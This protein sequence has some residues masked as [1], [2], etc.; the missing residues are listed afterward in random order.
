MPREHWG[1][2][3]SRNTV[4]QDEKGAMPLRVNNAPF[5]PRSCQFNEQ[6]IP[7]PIAG[8]TV[9][10][11]I[12]STA[13]DLELAPEIVPIP[14]KM[15]TGQWASSQTAL[16]AFIILHLKKPADIMKYCFITLRS[17]YYRSGHRLSNNTWGPL[18][19]K[20]TFLAHVV[21]ESYYTL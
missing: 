2:D 21:D 10:Q 9:T 7:S 8:S 3:S 16:P 11:Q 14:L 20:L 4:L 5:L 19:T 15:H 12:P 13:D 17:Q 6:P 1:P 18:A